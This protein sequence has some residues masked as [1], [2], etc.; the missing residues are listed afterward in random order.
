M[1]KDVRAVLARQTL[2]ID[3]NIYLQP[4]QHFGNL[5]VGQGPSIDE[6]VERGGD[7]PAQLASIISPERNRRDLEAGFIVMLEASRNHVGQYIVAEIGR[8]IGDA[9][10]VVTIALATPLRLRWP[11]A[12]VRPKS[13]ER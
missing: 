13:R 6:T 8:K 3:G 10:F 5:G 1:R 9:N 7:P 11:R 4:A 12:A 2:E